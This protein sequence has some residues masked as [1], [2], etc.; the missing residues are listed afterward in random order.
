MEKR[1]VSQRDR[2]RCSRSVIAK[3]ANKLL[4][5]ERKSFAKSMI[6]DELTAIKSRNLKCKSEYG[7]NKS[8]TNIVLEKDIHL[9]SDKESEAQQQKDA[10]KLVIRANDVSHKEKQNAKTC[11]GSKIFEHYKKDKK[12]EIDG[13]RFTFVEEKGCFQ[14]LFS[15]KELQNIDFNVNRRP[16]ARL[17]LQIAEKTG[18]GIIVTPGSKM[19]MALKAVQQEGVG[20][21][22][23]VGDSLSC[24]KEL[25]K[26]NEATVKLVPKTPFSEKEQQLD[27][28]NE[29]SMKVGQ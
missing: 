14:I 16:Q 25:Q 12:Y 3:S 18:C 6:G 22:V 5:A 29:T 27:Q 9:N 20:R 15:D 8:S 1:E 2:I 10:V 21:N 13:K 28:S 19:E 7:E 17:L 23:I 24:V 4:V 11:K 26:L